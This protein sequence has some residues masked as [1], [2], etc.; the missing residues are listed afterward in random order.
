[1]VFERVGMKYTSCVITETPPALC[2][3]LY[4]HTKKAPDTSNRV[5][6]ESEKKATQRIKHPKLTGT[7]GCRSVRECSKSTDGMDANLITFFAFICLA[8]RIARGK[9]IEGNCTPSRF[10]RN[11]RTRWYWNVIAVYAVHF[12][13]FCT[14]TSLCLKQ[15]FLK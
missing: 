7:T 8:E 15:Q 5:V 6:D 13:M 10:G 12:K 14:M 4:C 2:R 1:M 3:G 11:R 9:Q